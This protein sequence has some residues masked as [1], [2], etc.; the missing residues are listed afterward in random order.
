MCISSTCT[1]DTRRSACASSSARSGSGPTSVNDA[2]QRPPGARP[3]KGISSMGGTLPP[4][5]SGRRLGGHHDLHQSPGLLE[6]LQRDRTDD[7][8]RRRVAQLVEQRLLEHDLTCT[9]LTAETTP[10]VDGV[11]HDVVLTSTAVTHVCGDHL[12]GVE[13]DAEPHL[14]DVD[15]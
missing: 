2:H 6:A 8:D 15:L 10:D 14:G 11:A 13:P 1:S 9:R 5:P 4:V 12:A 3:A 7:L